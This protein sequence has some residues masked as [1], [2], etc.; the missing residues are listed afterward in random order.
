MFSFQG[1]KTD[2][3]LSGFLTEWTAVFP[4]SR[5]A[6][7]D[8]IREN[9]EMPRLASPLLRLS[10]LEKYTARMGDRYGSKRS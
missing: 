1:V 2:P 6:T 5:Q 7:A 9:Q 10:A 4:G 8:F 3:P